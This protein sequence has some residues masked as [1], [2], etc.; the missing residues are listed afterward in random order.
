MMDE[1]DWR[2]GALSRQDIDRLNRDFNEETDEAPRTDKYF[3]KQGQSGKEGT[4]L[5]SM[6]NA[7]NLRRAGLV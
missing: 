4:N 1:D 6:P 7:P 5:K 2:Q 3:G